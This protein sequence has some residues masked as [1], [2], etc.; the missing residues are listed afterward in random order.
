MDLILIII[1]LLLLFGAGPGNS[2]YGYRGGIGTGGVMPII[3]I[4]Y[5]LLRHERI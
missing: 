2:Y 5:P 4:V 3:L 1:V